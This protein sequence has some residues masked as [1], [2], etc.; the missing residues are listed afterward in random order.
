MNLVLDTHHR[1][2]FDRMIVA[3]C[4]AEDLSVV[5]LDPVFDKY[6]VQRLW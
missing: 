6:S 1:D 5:S 4:V 3:P 2:P